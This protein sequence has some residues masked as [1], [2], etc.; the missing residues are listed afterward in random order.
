MKTDP[1]IT[2]AEVGN[3]LAI[4]SG[5]VCVVISVVRLGALVDFIPGNF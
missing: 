5:I 4:F 1:T 2:P 3:A